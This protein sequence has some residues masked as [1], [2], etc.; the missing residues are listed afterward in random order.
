[1]A[2]LTILAIFGALWFML[3]IAA[4]IGGPFMVADVLPERLQQKL[5]KQYW[6]CSMKARGRTLVTLIGREVEILSS[7]REPRY[8]ERV[9]VEDERQDIPDP[10]RRMTTSYRERLGLAITEPAC[11]VDQRVCRLADIVATDV[12]HDRDAIW[13]DEDKSHPSYWETY[14]NVPAKAIGVDLAAAV[15]VLKGQ[16]KGNTAEYHEEIVSH[17]QEGHQKDKL[18]PDEWAGTMVFLAAFLIVFVVINVLGGSASLSGVM[19]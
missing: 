5:A 4:Y 19:G 16:A 11:V 18:I 7:S 9:T 12:E 3:G 17:S 14:I 8:G 10:D 1:M 13:T 2:S 6:W 15:N